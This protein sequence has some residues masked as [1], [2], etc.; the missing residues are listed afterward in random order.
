MRYKSLKVCP[1]C[2]G[3]L[4]YW[5]E[6]IITLEYPVNFETGKINK[7]SSNSIKESTDNEGYECKACGFLYNTIRDEQIR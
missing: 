6:K 4:V 1:K 7:R 3:A 5:K 2:G